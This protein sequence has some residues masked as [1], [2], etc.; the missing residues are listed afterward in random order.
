VEAPSQD[1]NLPHETPLL[2]SIERSSKLPHRRD[3][4]GT[5]C[6]PT[7]ACFDSP[8]NATEARVAHEKQLV[9]MQIVSY[10]GPSITMLLLIKSRDLNSLCGI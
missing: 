7:L 1:L 8:L 5:P 2:T 4:W 10:K 3:A 9:K 6:V